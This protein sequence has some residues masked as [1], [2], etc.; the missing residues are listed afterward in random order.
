MPLFTCCQLHA[1]HQVAQS[2]WWYSSCWQGYSVLFWRDIHVHGWTRTSH[3]RLC[4]LKNS[5][6]KKA[7]SPFLP[8]FMLIL[9]SHCRQI[10]PFFRR[11]NSPQQ[12]VFFFPSLP[13]NPLQHKTSSFLW[14]F[15]PPSIWSRFWAVKKCLCVLLTCHY[16]WQ[17]ENASLWFHDWVL[18]VDLERLSRRKVGVASSH[19]VPNSSSSSF[20]WYWAI[21]S[22]PTRRRTETDKS[23]KLQ[24]SMSLRYK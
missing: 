12:N 8:C 10:L 24:L 18:A 20:P 3:V 5:L 15:L 11:Y 7:G 4:M 9:F 6:D 2:W 23:Y 17:E 13:R 21:I 22:L 19:L 14:F 16:L 1:A